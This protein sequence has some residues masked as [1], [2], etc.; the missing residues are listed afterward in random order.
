[1][2]IRTSEEHDR[3]YNLTDVATTKIHTVKA[4][5]EHVLWHQLLGHPSFFVLSAS[6][7]FSK[8]IYVSSSPC[9]VCFRAKQTREVFPDI[10]NK[11][12]ECF[13][14][15]HCNVWGPYRLLSPCGAVY[16]FDNY[17]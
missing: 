4:T 5:L 15:I 10:F 11:L 6:P 7:L 1:M 13:A 17:R 3:I 16:F 2:L 9:D 12:K 14:L 8:S